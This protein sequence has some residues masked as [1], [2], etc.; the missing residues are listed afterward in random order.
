MAFKKGVSG[1]PSGRPRGTTES[2]RLRKQISKH[3]PE[4]AVFD[5]SWKLNDIGLVE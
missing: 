2:T 5:K 1:N 4:K 3:G